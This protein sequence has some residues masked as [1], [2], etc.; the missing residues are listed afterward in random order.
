MTFLKN[1]TLNCRF[2][3]VTGAEDFPAHNCNCDKIVLNKQV[4]VSFSQEK[5]INMADW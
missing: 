3:N 5:E 2:F 1:K 4:F